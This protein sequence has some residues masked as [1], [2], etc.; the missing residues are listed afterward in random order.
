[1]KEDT[2]D[3]K[4]IEAIEVFSTT[5]I[6][7]L[8]LRVC[9]G[10]TCCTTSATHRL[11]HGYS[12]LLERHLLRDCEGFVIRNNSYNVTVVDA[13]E[14][15]VFLTYIGLKAITIFSSRFKLAIPMHSCSSDNFDACKIRTDYAIQSLNVGVCDIRYAGSDSPISVQFCSKDAC[16]NSGILDKVGRNDFEKGDWMTFGIH[17]LAKE[18]QHFPI[19]TIDLQVFVTN[20]GSDALCID[21]FQIKGNVQG[22]TPKTLNCYIPMKP[23]FWVES[24]SLKMICD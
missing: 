4:T 1:M 10:D 15:E 7:Y 3:S 16:C 8:A 2:F 11:Y 22:D 5:Y 21:K 14:N 13:S 6:E 12:K 23:E 19:S 18:C 20:L 24:A 17:E 9:S